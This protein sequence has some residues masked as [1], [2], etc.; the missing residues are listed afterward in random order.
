MEVKKPVSRALSRRFFIVFIVAVLTVVCVTPAEA[1]TPQKTVNASAT[2]FLTVK[3]SSTT[4][5]FK[6]S[7]SAQPICM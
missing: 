1:A 2:L 6:T 7:T 4:S 3:A 5:S